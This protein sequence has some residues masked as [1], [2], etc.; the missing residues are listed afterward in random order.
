MLLLWGNGWSPATCVAAEETATV[1]GSCHACLHVPQVMGDESI[2]WRC[3]VCR[4]EMTIS[5]RGKAVEP[6]A[7]EHEGMCWDCY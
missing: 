6:T 4:G 3:A 5:S 7:T 2:T 1:I